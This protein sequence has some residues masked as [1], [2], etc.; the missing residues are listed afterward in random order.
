M[1]IY[2]GVVLMVLAV[3]QIGRAQCNS[4]EISKE[5]IIDLYQVPVKE[6]PAWKVEWA[7][8]TPHFFRLVLEESEGEK[9]AWRV[10]DAWGTSSQF[11]NGMCIYML[12]KKPTQTSSGKRFWLISARL[13]G[14]NNAMKMWKSCE[15]SIP[16]VDAMDEMSVSAGNPNELLSIRSEGRA[17][18]LRMEKSETPF[19]QK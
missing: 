15:F 3:A 19:L 17:Y 9:G 4:V 18:R 1:K 12:H 6:K 7:V 13:G 14:Q 11:T 16:A 10:R 8:D 2:I 5:E